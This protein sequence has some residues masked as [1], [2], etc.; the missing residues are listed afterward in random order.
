MFIETA[1]QYCFGFEPEGRIIMKKNEYKKYYN[2]PKFMEEDLGIDNPEERGK[3][4]IVFRFL[5]NA[6]LF[7]LV[8]SL[9]ICEIEE[10]SGVY[11][12]YGMYFHRIFYLSLLFSLLV[13]RRTF[14]PSIVYHV[15]LVP[16]LTTGTLTI[17]YIAYFSEH[18]SLLFFLTLF[19]SCVCNISFVRKCIQEM[20]D[21]ANFYQSDLLSEEEIFSLFKKGYSVYN[22][23]TL[24]IKRAEENSHCTEEYENNADN[25]GESFSG[26]DILDF[27][28]EEN[29][30]VE[31]E[32]GMDMPEFEP[33]TDPEPEP[34][35]EDSRNFDFKDSKNL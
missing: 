30:E 15:F 34:D 33:E 5:A 2:S 6:F 3:A 12:L 23:C 19:V 35:F 4:E 13:A 1:L 26:S 27:E 25:T 9:L 24:G 21:V 8:G 32:P 7:F 18:A 14:F 17:L 16:L 31:A 11:N 28:P 22:V 29:Q 10:M 20:K